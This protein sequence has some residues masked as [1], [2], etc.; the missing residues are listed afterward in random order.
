[1]K[2]NKWK[3]DV[4]TKNLKARLAKAESANISLKNDMRILNSIKNEWQKTSEEN[5]SIANEL[6]S[7]KQWLEYALKSLSSFIVNGGA[8]DIETLCKRVSN[9]NNEDL[10]AITNEIVAKYEGINSS[11]V[12]L[13]NVDKKLCEYEKEI[14]GLKSEN[15]EKDLHIESLE[16]QLE[17]ANKCIVDLAEK[18]DKE[19]H[20]PWWKKVFNRG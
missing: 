19:L 1:M 6:H 17:I 13:K 3:N 14:D 9:A 20:K 10:T 2:R 12:L 8:S 4:K 18:L 7:E 16:K 15:N 11:S 5:E